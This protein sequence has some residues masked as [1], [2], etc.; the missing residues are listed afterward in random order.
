MLVASSSFDRC[1][2]GGRYEIQQLNT[3]KLKYSQVH[4]QSIA[5]YFKPHIKVTESQVNLKLNVDQK[6][7]YFV[8]FLYQ[9]LHTRRQHISH[10]DT[11][12]LLCS[13]I[14]LVTDSM[15]PD[16]ELPSL[17]SG[18]QRYWKTNLQ[19]AQTDT[20]TC[21][22]SQDYLVQSVKHLLE[23][24]QHWVQTGFGRSILFHTS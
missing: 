19:S 7:F 21:H 9:I 13:S 5:D 4:T 10:F 1:F 17:Y 8:N 20:T 11:A 14:T 23:V 16:I 2:L 15:P 6:R 22:S 24:T 3:Q 18:K 12:L